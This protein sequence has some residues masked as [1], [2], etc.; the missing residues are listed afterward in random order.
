[1][2]PREFHKLA[3]R[4]AT[5]SDAAELRSATSRA[6]YAVYNVGAEFLN[7]IVPLSRGAASHGQVQK[8]L[9]NCGNAAVVEV[10]RKLRGMHARRI[11]AD[12]EMSDTTCENQS[13]VQ[14]TVV[15]ARDMIDK[16]DAAFTG[17]T[18][19]VLKKAIQE[20]WTLILRE[21][22]RGRKPIA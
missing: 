11:D 8:L 4:L 10:G 14:A 20:Y 22:L 12:Y 18:S 16:I 21:P 1:M 19:R 5:A 13:S 3:Q 17:S 6:Y 2:N 15:E 9:A 7:Q